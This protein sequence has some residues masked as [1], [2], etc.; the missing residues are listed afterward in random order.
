M[1]T[2][3]PKTKKEN[4]IKKYKKK[5]RVAIMYS[6]ATNKQTNKQLCIIAII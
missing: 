3:K 2:T 4:E 5:M 6:R 1:H